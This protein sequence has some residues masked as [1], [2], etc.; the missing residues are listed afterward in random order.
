M[1]KGEKE[2]VEVYCLRVEHRDTEAQRAYFE[3]FKYSVSL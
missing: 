1:K 3:L 2:G